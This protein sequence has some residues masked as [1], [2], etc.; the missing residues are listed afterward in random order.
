MEDFLEPDSGEFLDDDAKTQDLIDQENDPNIQGVTI[1]LD[2][3]TPSARQVANS[4]KRAWM[5]GGGDGYFLTLMRAK[6]EKFAD[7]LAKTLPKDP[8]SESPSQFHVEI[9]SY[10][11]PARISSADEA[12][13]VVI[14]EDGEDAKPPD[15]TPI[16]IRDFTDE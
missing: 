4:L 2:I 7:I 14:D 3:P 12:S 1:V 6:P 11:R 13:G 10:D 15:S 5:A 8:E 9:K 16:A